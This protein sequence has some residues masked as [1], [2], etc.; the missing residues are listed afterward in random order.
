MNRSG[1][2]FDGLYK[3][4]MDLWF[5]R[6]LLTM[7]ENDVMNVGVKRGILNE[8]SLALWHKRLGHI[9]QER[10]KRSVND[11]VLKALTFTDFGVD[12]GCIKGKQPKD[13]NKHETVR[14]LEWF[15]LIHADIY[16]Y[17]LHPAGGQRCFINF[18]DDFSRYGCLPAV[19]EV[20]YHLYR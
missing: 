9:S 1:I 4:N 19:G 20:F 2:L 15:K 12:I 11:R 3:L 16:V 13:I 6:S 8:N 10:M 7:H 17:L 14:C 18:I 5:V